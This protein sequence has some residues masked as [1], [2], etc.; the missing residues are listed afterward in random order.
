MYPAT[1]SHPDGKLRL[2]YEC[3]PMAFLA[4]NA[5]GMAMDGKKRILDVVPTE[6][7]QRVPLFTGSK[8]MVEKAMEFVLEDELVMI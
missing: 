4:E 8:D 6:L 1:T 5:G 7:H 2:L 3:N